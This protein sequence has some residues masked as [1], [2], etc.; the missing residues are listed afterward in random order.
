MHVRFSSYSPNCHSSL[1]RKPPRPST[2]SYPISPTH[3]QPHHPTSILT[4]SSHLSIPF[5]TIPSLTTN[6]LKLI[7]PSSPIRFPSTPLTSPATHPPPTSPIHPTATP[8][9]HLFPSTTFLT[10]TLAKR[11]MKASL[12][13]AIALQPHSKYLQHLPKLV[14]L[15]DFLNFARDCHWDAEDGPRKSVSEIYYY[16]LVCL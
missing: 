4:Q 12:T 11:S 9:P 10:P 2:S 5:S 6:Y 13:H 3:A 7:S 8:I 1:I 16:S 15:T 14:P